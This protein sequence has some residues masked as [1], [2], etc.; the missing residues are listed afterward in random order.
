MTALE[1][2]ALLATGAIWSWCVSNASAPGVKLLAWAPFVLSQLF[3]FRALDL[4]SE[5]RRIQ[6]YL[7]AVEATISLPDGLGWHRYARTQSRSFQ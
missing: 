6:R 1:R 3:G 2:Y 4:G 5:L 7:A